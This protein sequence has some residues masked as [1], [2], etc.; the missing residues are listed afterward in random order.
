MSEGI[1]SGV[2]EMGYPSLCHD[3]AFHGGPSDRLAKG[4]VK[5][6]DQCADAVLP[7]TVLMI[8]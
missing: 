6:R 3:M 8:P 2:I 5:N 7:S 1:G 4:H